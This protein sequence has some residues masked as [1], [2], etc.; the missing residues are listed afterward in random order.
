M[1]FGSVRISSSISAVLF[2]SE[3]LALLYSSNLR[4]SSILASSSLTSAS[5]YRIHLCYKDSGGKYIIVSSAVPMI[6]GEK[7][8]QYIKRIYSNSAKSLSSKELEYN[9]ISC[10]KNKKIYEMIKKKCS[11]GYFKSWKKFADMGTVLEE[12]KNVFNE[13]KLPDQ[14]NALTEIIKILKSGRSVF[15]DLSLLGESKQSCISKLGAVLTSSK[16][17]KDIRLI[18]QSPT[19]LYEKRSVNLLDL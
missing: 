7:E 10:E 2:S 17:I 6:C 11:E 5:R 13:L 19:G 9:G 18:D 15:C 3:L 1:S 14:V 4:F 12:K 16:Y 8:E